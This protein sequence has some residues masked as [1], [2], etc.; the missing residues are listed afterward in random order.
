[1]THPRDQNT[2]QYKYPLVMLSRTSVLRLH[3]VPAR[4]TYVRL[5]RIKYTPCSILT[6]SIIM[7]F[8]LGDP[9][10]T[11]TSN[12]HSALTLC[13]RD[14]HTSHSPLQARIRLNHRRHLDPFRHP[15]G[16]QPHVCACSMIS[17]FG[18]VSNPATSFLTPW[19]IVN[20]CAFMILIGH[21]V[22]QTTI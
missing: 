6:R 16:I 12:S 19:K 2:E 8:F 22:W 14:G 10:L 17:S 21:C 1:M 18:S 3:L 5:V 20:L 13:G 11:H 7:F 4:C 15:Q 9:P